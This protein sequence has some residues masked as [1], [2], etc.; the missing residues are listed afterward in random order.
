MAERV[1][2]VRARAFWS[3]TITFGLVNVPV[4]LFPANR[5]GGVSLRMLA[6]DGTP[7]EREYY[8]PETGKRVLYDEVV[9]GYEIEKG[10]FVLVDEGELERLEPEKT[11]EID[12]RRFVPAADIDPMHFERAYFLAPAAGSNKAYRLL[13]EAMEKTGMAGIAT[14]V[15]RTKEYL[16][17]ILAEDG[18]L[19]AET[20]RF[21]DELRDPS[22]AG[23]DDLPDAKPAEVKRF[24]KA[25]RARTEKDIDEKEL[26]DDWADRVLGLVKR[27]EDAGE[28][29]VKVADEEAVAGTDVIDLMAVLKRSMAEAGAETEE[30]ENGGARPKTRKKS[31]GTSPLKELTREEL[32][33]RARELDI[34]GRSSMTKAQLLRAIEKAA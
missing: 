8:D 13:A 15:M 3:G 7:L 29:V 25:I 6:P 2:D 12:L 20:L 34:P 31:G 24:E 9:R 10:E 28:D 27:K 1:E 23:L 16:V 33:Q 19:R 5:P 22:A 26:T 11:R 18:I 32:Y 14:F 17:A 4:A 21:A 30:K